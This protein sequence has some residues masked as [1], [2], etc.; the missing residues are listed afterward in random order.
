MLAALSALTAN[1]IS[2]SLNRPARLNKTVTTSE[3]SRG[4]VTSIYNQAQLWHPISRW[5]S[6]F[7]APNT[8]WKENSDWCQHKAKLSTNGKCELTSSHFLAARL[9][10]TRSSVIPALGH[11][12]APCTLWYISNPLLAQNKS[13]DLLIFCTFT[14]GC[15]SSYHAHK[16]I[17]S[18]TLHTR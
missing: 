6:Y 3:V 15:C 16:H 12:A 17:A 7:L 18:Y 5:S 8:T 10:H 11:L 2:A 13:N 9:Q 1:C 4:S 14:A